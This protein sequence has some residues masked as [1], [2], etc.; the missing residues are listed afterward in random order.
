[1]PDFVKYPDT[2]ARFTGRSSGGGVVKSTASS[3]VLPDEVLAFG[4][5]K[6]CRDGLEVRCVV[7]GV[8]HCPP[9]LPISAEA[10]GLSVCVVVVA[11]RGGLASV[12]RKW[13]SAASG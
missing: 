8:S 13:R 1:M 9:S 6:E 7:S 4:V 12:P 2:F 11:G 3:R 5:K 10:L